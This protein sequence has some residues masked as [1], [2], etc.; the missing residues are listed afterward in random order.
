MKGIL[1]VYFVASAATFLVYGF[2]KLAAKR[3]WWRVRESTL[4]LLEAVGGWPGAMLA[5]RFFRHKSYKKSFRRV[6]WAMVALN[7]LTLVVIV[8]FIRDL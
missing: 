1:T 5:H 6:F 3:N 8:K 4:H 7:V 2:D